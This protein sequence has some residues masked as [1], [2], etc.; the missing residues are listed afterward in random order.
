[1]TIRLLRINDM[2]DNLDLCLH[3]VFVRRYFQVA[4]QRKTAHEKF[5]ATLMK[6]SKIYRMVQKC[7]LVVL[8]YVE[9]QKI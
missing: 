6:Q 4:T 2:L 3:F 9:F 5:S 8:D 1:M 7:W